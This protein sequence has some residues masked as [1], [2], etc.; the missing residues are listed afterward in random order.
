MKNPL[1]LL[2]CSLMLSGCGSIEFM[3]KK[4]PV[5][6]VLPTQQ[7]R[8]AVDAQRRELSAASVIALTNDYRLI[9]EPI[10]NAQLLSQLMQQTIGNPNQQLT[11]TQAIQMMHTVIAK[12]QVAEDKFVKQIETLSGKSV[13]STGLFSIPRLFLTMSIGIGLVLLYVIY[14]V[15]GM[16]YPV[17]GIAGSAFTRISSSLASKGFQSVVKGIETAK[18]RIDTELDQHTASQVKDI[19]RSEQQKAQDADV[20]TVIKKITI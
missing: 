6:P 4:V 19:I 12:Q 14:K 10:A 18:E 1:I 20:Q 13:E 11:A 8:N 5:V 2:L 15:L 16:L 9:L 17:V 3:K 7:L